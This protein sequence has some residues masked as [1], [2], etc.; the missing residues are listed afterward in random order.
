[1]T[2]EPSS[3]IDVFRAFMNEP[4]ASDTQ[5]S[6][7]TFQYGFIRSGTENFKNLTEEDYPV[8]HLNKPT[9]I[10]EGDNFNTEFRYMCDVTVFQKYSNQGDRAENEL[11]EQEGDNVCVGVLQQLLKFLNHANKKSPYTTKFCFDGSEINPVMQN[12][13]DRHV[14]WNLAFSVNMNVN[15]KLC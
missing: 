3:L 2:K 9:I 4:S 15:A 12:Y 5:I 6:A 10:P 1:M 8:L 14:G 13:V 11:N 7:K